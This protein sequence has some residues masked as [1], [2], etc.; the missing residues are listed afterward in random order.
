MLRV[1]KAGR[2]SHYKRQLPCG[3]SCACDDQ[4][5]SSNHTNMGY[6]GKA[7]TRIEIRLALL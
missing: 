5:L 3:L 2:C 1:L 7:H 6:N 4:L